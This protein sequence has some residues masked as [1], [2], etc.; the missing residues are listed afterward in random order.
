M[1]VG[2]VQQQ[3]RDVGNVLFC[4]VFLH[5]RAH[6][7]TYLYFFHITP[8]YV[9]L[10]AD[11]LF[12]QAVEAKQQCML[13]ASGLVRCTLPL[14]KA[15]ATPSGTTTLLQLHAFCE[16]HAGKD[17]GTNCF[18]GTYNS[19]IVIY[20]IVLWSYSTKYECELSGSSNVVDYFLICVE[21]VEWSAVDHAFPC[22]SQDALVRRQ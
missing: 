9:T 12:G 17:K 10:D 8:C 5:V 16:C 14:Y 13:Y 20:Q 15:S 21:G 11:M 22:P 7:H 6:K 2:W 1:T 4:G 3:Y 18:Y 19:C